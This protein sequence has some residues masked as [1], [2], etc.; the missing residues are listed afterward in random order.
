MSQTRLS[1]WLNKGTS[2]DRKVFR[3]VA[4]AD[5]ADQN[6]V[7]P[8]KTGYDALSM[9]KRQEKKSIDHIVIAGHGGPTW[10]LSPVTGIVN[11]AT[12]KT[13][14]D[15]FEF[16]EIVDFVAK[17][18]LLISIAACLCSRSP[19]W[20]LRLISAIGSDWGPR[21]YRKGGIK[22]FSAKLRDSLLYHG[23]NVRVRGHRVS[24]H[25]GDCAILAEHKTPPCSPCETLFERSLPGVEPMLK[26]RHWWVANVTGELAQNWLLGNDSVESVILDKYNN[27]IRKK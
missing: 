12:K 21:G 2:E 3:K 22:S 5:G 6:I 18:N 19:A 10:L 17:D 16:S 13:Q 24:G 4:E 8:I 14:T 20:Y 15:V 9:L 1:F 26:V 7:V 11:N 23:C 27:W 25:A